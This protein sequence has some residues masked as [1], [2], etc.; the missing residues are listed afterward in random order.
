MRKFIGVRNMSKRNYFAEILSIVKNNVLSE[1][2]SGK[3]INEK[4]EQKIT[5]IGFYPQGV[6][7]YLT[8]QGAFKVANVSVEKDN[9]WGKKYV[10]EFKDVNLDAPFFRSIK[11]LSVN[12]SDRLEYND[13]YRAEDNRYSSNGNI[14]GFDAYYCDDT[15][16][17]KLSREDSCVFELFAQWLG[18]NNY[19]DFIQNN[20][21]TDAEI[22]LLYTKF[23]EGALASDWMIGEEE[24]EDLEV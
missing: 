22:D 3:Y 11:K 7:T 8:R 23:R 1:K 19:E 10:I 9:Y 12:T 5:S 17:E 4:K 16:Y 14:V 13:Q 6:I 20:K 24:E 15:K 21:R 2:F 18:Y